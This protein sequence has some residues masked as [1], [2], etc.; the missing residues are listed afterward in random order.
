MAGNVLVP[1]WLTLISSW[2]RAGEMSGRWHQPTRTQVQHGSE[3]AR[4]ER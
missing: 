4:G 1:P 2:Q 3:A